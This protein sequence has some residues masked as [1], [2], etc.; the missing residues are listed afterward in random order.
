MLSAMPSWLTLLL[1]LI[2][3]C[4]PS[5]PAHAPA[6]EPAPASVDAQAASGAQH[7]AHGLHKD[8]SDA[9]RY[10]QHFDDPARDAWQRPND[11]IEHLRIAPGSTVV[12]LGAGTGYF[13][14]ALSNAVG[15]TG[16]VIALDVEPEMVSFMQRRV[17]EQALGNV[18]PQQVAA[19]DPGLAS[20]SVARVLVVNTWHHLDQRAA[21]ARKLSQALAAS[22]EIWVVDFTLDADP[23]PPAAHRLA[24]EQVVRELEQGGLR[25]E[26]FTA[27]QLPKQY[28]VRAW[29]E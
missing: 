23:G 16:K 19:D 20:G 1:V 27:E 22:G 4:Q 11:V 14:K 10:A 6:G 29:R 15:P 3:A 26:I 24:P 17:R 18:T 8:F 25:A 13:L 28:M 2:C 5:Q 9:E 21:Y 12:D 7:G